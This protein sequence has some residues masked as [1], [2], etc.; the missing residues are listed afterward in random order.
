MGLKA[1]LFSEDQ[2]V[3]P[4]S[5]MQM[6]DGFFCARNSAIKSFRKV[7]AG[8]WYRIKTELNKKE[9]LNVKD[10]VAA[11]LRVRICCSIFDCPGG[12]E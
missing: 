12:L 3:G 9:Y 8:R 5:C 1:L 4:P 2:M 7:N 11:A 10:C 6:Q